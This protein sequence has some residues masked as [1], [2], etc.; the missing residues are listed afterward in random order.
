MA[1]KVVC[2]LVLPPQFDMSILMTCRTLAKDF[3]LCINRFV[4]GPVEVAN[5]RVFCDPA[6]QGF[7]LV[8]MVVRSIAIPFS[9]VIS[10]FEIEPQSY[11]FHVLSF[12]GVP[13][14]PIVLEPHCVLCA[15]VVTVL[16]IGGFA[17]S[18]S[19][20]MLVCILTCRSPL[21]FGC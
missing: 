13:S 16:M 1:Q 19:F 4:S 11:L 17:S 20:T 3:F 21:D 6:S 2:L 8:I 18:L 12:M 7:S 14:V 9:S 15:N 10:L 5:P